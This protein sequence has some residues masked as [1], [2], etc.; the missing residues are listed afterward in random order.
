[1]LAQEE[2]AYSVSPNRSK[3][4]SPFQIVY[5]MHPRG[6]HELT[7]LGKTKKRSVDGE[8]LGNAM[9]ELYEELK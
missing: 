1:M 3:G 5:G 4:K 2:Y 9:Q 7:D 6:V 8:E